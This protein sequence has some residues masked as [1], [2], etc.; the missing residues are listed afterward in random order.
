MLKC[1]KS[2]YVVEEETHNNIKS[3]GRSRTKKPTNNK[4]K[5]DKDDEKLI[6]TNVE[7]I[8]MSRS[9]VHQCIVMH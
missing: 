5:Q 8:E 2:Q 4:M 6:H 9:W 7:R 3:W 1:K